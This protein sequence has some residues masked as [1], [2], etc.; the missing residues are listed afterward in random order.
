MLHF[1]YF[2]VILLFLAMENVNQNAI[3]FP[4][5]EGLLLEPC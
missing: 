4:L 5:K 2:T 1:T 3:I